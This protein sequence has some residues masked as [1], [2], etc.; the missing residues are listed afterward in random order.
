MDPETV[1]LGMDMAVRE[2]GI[3][4]ES[5]VPW[6]Y[7]HT[8]VSSRVV[9]HICGQARIMRKKVWGPDNDIDLFGV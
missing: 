3:N 1:L 6:D 4:E 9:R 8:D 7:R 2:R 5:R